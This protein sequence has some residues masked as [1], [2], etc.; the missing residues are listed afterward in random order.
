MLSTFSTSYKAHLMS[1]DNLIHRR[2]EC[3]TCLEI[4]ALHKMLLLPSKFV[5]F[6][7]HNRKSRGANNLKWKATEKV[8][9]IDFSCTALDKHI[10]AHCNWIF[11]NMWNAFYWQTLT[12]ECKGAPKSAVCSSC[13]VP[14][15]ISWDS[16]LP[17][18]A[19]PNALVLLVQTRKT[20]H[21]KDFDKGCQLDRFASLPFSFV[22]LSISSNWLIAWLI[23]INLSSNRNQ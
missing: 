7:F 13:K 22:L 6:F 12:R 3:A 18:R 10:H 21:K 15:I 20:K 19:M 9:S 17:K 1:A 16:E 23:V 5:E 11:L 2:C 8:N 14:E 4:I